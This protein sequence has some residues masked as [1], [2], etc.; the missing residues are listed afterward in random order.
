MRMLVI[1]VV[2][3]VFLVLGPAASA[4]AS[5]AQEN[6]RGGGHAGLWGLLGL[7]GLLGLAG[8]MSKSRRGP[9]P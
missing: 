8:M 3:G 1:P 6:N 9:R 2:L 4:M 7:L 5:L